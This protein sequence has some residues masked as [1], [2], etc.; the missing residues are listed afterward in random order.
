MDRFFIPGIDPH[1]SR[2]L[3]S[4]SRQSST[5]IPHMGLNDALR[6]LWRFV[7]PVVVVLAALVYGIL[8][9]LYATFYG[10]LGASPED[11][12][13]GY[14]QMLSLSTVTILAIV[15]VSGAFFLARFFLIRSNVLKVKYRQN[16]SIL[17][18][19]LA[20]LLLAGGV[21]WLFA[22]TNDGATRAYLGQPVTSAGVGDIQVLGLRAEPAIIEW[23]AKPTGPDT[24]SGHCLMYL[25]TADG[26]A[27]FFD[28]GPAIRTIRLPV[29]AIT[30][31][32]YRVLPQPDGTNPAAACSGGRLVPAS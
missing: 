14:Q 16:A 21:W 9:Q 5:R 3:A 28:P 20:V 29:S 30:V 8:R 1:L 22:Q 19:V 31:T 32:I 11:V 6:W 10:R 7:L 13:L 23:S 15:V 27:V 17:G 18:A 24:I 4:C 12:G 2:Y 25:G 26:A